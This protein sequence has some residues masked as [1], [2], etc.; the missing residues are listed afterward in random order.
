MPVLLHAVCLAA[1]AS[2]VEDVARAPRHT[3]SSAIIGRYRRWGWLS[4][5]RPATLANGS[6]ETIHRRPL[7]L[8][9]LP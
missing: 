4:T 9:D 5:H 8:P 3:V 7:V 1:G 2:T 6:S